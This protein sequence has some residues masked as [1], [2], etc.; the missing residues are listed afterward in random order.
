MDK[1]IF[2]WSFFM[3]KFNQ[4]SVVALNA[5]EMA[6]INGG[7]MIA[8]PIQFALKVAETCKNAWDYICGN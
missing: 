5:A 1:Q 6:N 2:Y 3:E 4:S 8:L 7:S